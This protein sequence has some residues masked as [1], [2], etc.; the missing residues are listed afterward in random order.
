MRQHTATG[1]TPIWSLLASVLMAG[2]VASTIVDSLSA[3][4][5]TGR[6]WT[7]AYLVI[8][9]ML[10]AVDGW[11]VSFVQS[12]KDQIRW[13]YRLLEFAGLAL[14][15]LLPWIG[16]DL[17][18][19]FQGRQ[20]NLDELAA[21][22]RLAI[23]T[24]AAYQM[25]LLTR[26]FAHAMTADLLRINQHQVD[27]ISS[28]SQATDSLSALQKRI[29]GA[30][31]AMLLAMAIA[32]G[33]AQF[34]RIESH[35]NLA[36]NAIAIFLYSTTS[37]LLL[38][39]AQFAILHNSWKES[40]ASISSGIQSQWLRSNLL[41]IVLIACMAFVL[42]TP[43]SLMPNLLPQNGFRPQATST[44]T[45]SLKTPTPTPTPTLRRAPYISSPNNKKPDVSFWKSLDSSLSSIWNNLALLLSQVVA[46][47]PTIFLFVAGG[48]ILWMLRGLFRKRSVTQLPS[49]APIQQTK[50]PSVATA[51][52]A[53]FTIRRPSTARDQIHAYYLSVLQRARQ[54]GLE[55]R[56]GQTPYEY[57]A[58]LAS[59][60]PD[61][62]EALNQLTQAFIEA[63]YSQQDIETEDVN[64]ARTLWQKLRT[65][66]RT[67]KQKSSR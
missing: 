39:Q 17:G 1:S 36:A 45:Y 38:G 31:G 54:S 27:D 21:I 5:F 60:L 4:F 37:L 57:T 32:F 26:R 22:A 11:R 42:P 28:K 16:A 35:L 6:S 33:W 9:C 49:P 8:A 34:N 13:P 2:C 63:Q 18:V 41:L 55:R 56:P 48:I 52:P 30:G 51:Q 65:T 64:Q 40:K 14:F 24:F 67:Y 10:A 61:S 62:Q 53:T 25:I 29:L 43:T 66:L 15:L 58:Q 47:T 7:G 59:E 50:S 20:T 23:W 44:P 46:N 3:N 19:L 12:R